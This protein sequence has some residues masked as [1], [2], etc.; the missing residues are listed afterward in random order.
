MRCGKLCKLNIIYVETKQYKIF[1][2][3]LQTPNKRRI[4][5]SLDVACSP[6]GSKAISIHGGTIL[7]INQ[8]DILWYASPQ[9]SITVRKQIA[10]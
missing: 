1:N 10:L 5:F 2:E 8:L 6:R 4:Q 7:F 3:G 9:G